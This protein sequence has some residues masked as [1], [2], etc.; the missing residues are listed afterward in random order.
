MDVLTNNSFDGLALI[1]S[2]IGDFA[3]VLNRLGFDKPE[4]ITGSTRTLRTGVPVVRSKE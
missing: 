2:A 3:N 1:K 4:I